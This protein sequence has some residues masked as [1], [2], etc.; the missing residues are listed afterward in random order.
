ME[1]II[2]ILEEKKQGER[3]KLHLFGHECSKGKCAQSRIHFIDEILKEIRGILLG[4]K[5]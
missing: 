3:E 1:G 2:K 5:K 4:G